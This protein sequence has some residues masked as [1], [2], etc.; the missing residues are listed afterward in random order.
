MKS[1]QQPMDDTIRG[2]RGDRRAVSH[3]AQTARLGDL[4]KRRYLRRA[5]ISSLFRSTEID[6]G[7]RD[8]QIE[9]SRL[10]TREP[11]TGRPNCPET[12]VFLA[13]SYGCHS[14]SIPPD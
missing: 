3:A 4:T 5:L 11:A 8:G 7:G 6:R 9:R 12:L 13:E 1:W 14:P 10:S 2:L